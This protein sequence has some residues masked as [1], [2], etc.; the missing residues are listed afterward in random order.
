MINRFDKEK[1]E[2]LKKRDGSEFTEDEMILWQYYIC[3]MYFGNPFEADENSA[4]I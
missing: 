2:D 3:Q 4:E 1:L